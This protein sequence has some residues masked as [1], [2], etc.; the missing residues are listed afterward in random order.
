MNHGHYNC[1][2]D[3]IIVFA[4][5][6]WP[7]NIVC[8]THLLVKIY[9]T[10]SHCICT[11]LSKVAS[12]KLKKIT[13]ILICPTCVLGKNKTG[14]YQILL[15]NV[16]NFQIIKSDFQDYVKYYLLLVTLPS[17]RV[18]LRNWSKKGT[19]MENPTH[20]SAIIT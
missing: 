12:A 6:F 14:T 4:T 2:S 7:V 13:F 16:K 10:N 17:L 3:T 11:C 9:N 5:I 15:S 8:T 18:M 20:A 1:V 19:S